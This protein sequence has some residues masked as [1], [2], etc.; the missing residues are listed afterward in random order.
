MFSRVQSNWPGWN[1]LSVFVLPL[2]LLCDIGLGL[3]HSYLVSLGW[4][5]WS[6]CKDL[7]FKPCH[8]MDLSLV[9]TSQMRSGMT[10]EF[11]LLFSLYPWRAILTSPI[12]SALPFLLSALLSWLITAFMLSTGSSELIHTEVW[13]LNITMLIEHNAFIKIHLLI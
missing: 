7:D 2:Q 12:V 13:I 3:G 10:L 5:H 9:V 4:S 8:Q 11:W 1:D 6:Q